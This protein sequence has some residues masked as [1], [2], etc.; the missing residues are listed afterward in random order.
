MLAKADLRGA[1]L[2]GANLNEADLG[3]ADLSGAN[4]TG[5]DLASANLSNAS[6]RRANLRDA[7]LSGVNFLGADLK[8]AIFEP[9]PNFF[10]S[11]HNLA[12]ANGLADLRYEK[13]PLSLVK[14]GRAFNEAGYHRQE[15]E[16]SCSLRRSEMVRDWQRGGLAGMK[17]AFTYVFWD[18]TCAYGLAPWRP[19]ALWGLGVL[20]F[21][22]FYCLALLSRRADTGI[23]RVWPP[24][25]VLRAEGR[26]EPEKLTT[27]PGCSPPA[28]GA[29]AKAWWHLRRLLRIPVIGFY[30]SLVAALSLSW[31]G[32]GA[33]SLVSR[34][35]KR[36]Y[37][38]KPTGWVRTV[39]GIQSLMSA[40]L[41]ILWAFRYLFSIIGQ[42]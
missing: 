4:L 9:H 1:N 24:D 33:G 28:R 25:R 37:L 13:Y 39:A 8:G 2:S 38:L 3:G 19:L 27:T 32:P 21:F 26:E 20:V 6:L 31:R 22:P 35:Q 7:R 30:F 17:A 12:L 5:A 29:L 42:K 40:F 14:L 16:V 18:L 41:L 15:S 23:W 36:E 34:L 10:P 11:V